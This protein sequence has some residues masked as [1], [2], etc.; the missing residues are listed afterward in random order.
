MDNKFRQNTMELI[1]SIRLTYVR[2][3]VRFRDFQ[4]ADMVRITPS[5][6]SRLSTGVCTP[7]IDVYF[8]LLAI[9]RSQG[10]DILPF[11]SNLISL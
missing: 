8:R 5:Q 2:S 1:R 11:I 6:L 7:S 4:L 9:R 3:D 10:Y